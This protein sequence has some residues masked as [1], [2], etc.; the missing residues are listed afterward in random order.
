MSYECKIGIPEVERV[1]PCLDSQSKEPLMSRRQR[2]ESSSVE[3][4]SD[5]MTDDMETPT[6]GMCLRHLQ[7]QSRMHAASHKCLTCIVSL[8]CS[9]RTRLLV[10]RYSVRSELK[11]RLVQLAYSLLSVKFRLSVR[12]PLDTKIQQPPDWA[13]RSL[14]QRICHW[15]PRFTT[16][17]FGRFVTRVS[18]T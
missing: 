10:P 1:C 2:T 5:I 7:H 17:R 9:P 13:V 3:F 16:G 15:Q 11:I 12:M 14:S 8:K 18:R 6:N 4:G